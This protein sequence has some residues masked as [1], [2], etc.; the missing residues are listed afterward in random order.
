MQVA[1]F[2]EISN[3][4]QIGDQ[5]WWNYEHEVLHSISVMSYQDITFDSCDRGRAR[6]Q[7]S[8]YIVF[9]K[10]EEREVAIG[11]FRSIENQINDML[12]DDSLSNSG[13]H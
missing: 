13:N 4:L 1:L 5:I 8:E 6:H 2:N 12:T 10:E 9:A 11:M 3:Y 7:S